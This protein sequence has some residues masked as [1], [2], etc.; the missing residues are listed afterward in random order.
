MS[1]TLELVEHPLDEKRDEVMQFM[2][3]EH[4]WDKRV[5]SYVDLFRKILS[6]GCLRLA[7]QMKTLIRIGI[8]SG[9]DW[10][11]ALC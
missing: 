5:D 7:K 6:A 2:A 1:N 3:A 11:K 8:Q 10:G 9:E 4:S